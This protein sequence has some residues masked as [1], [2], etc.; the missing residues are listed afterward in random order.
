MNLLLGVMAAIAGYLFGSISAARLVVRLAATQ[1]EVAKIAVE[2]PGYDIVFESDSVSAS[3]VR[4]Q[5][6]ARYG[7]LTA[8]VDMLKIALPTLAVRLWQPNDAYYL[9]LAGAGVLGHAWPL[10]Y[11]FQGGRGESPILGGLL[12][13]DAVGLLVTT[14]V[15]WCLGWVTGNLLVL[16]W[17]FLGLMIPWFWFRTHDFA[18]VLY[19]A[20]VNIVYWIAMLPEIR[21]YF[22]FRGQEQSPTQEELSRFWGMGGHVGRILDRHSLPALF[23][24]K[25]G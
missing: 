13:V 12:A 4:L 20:F 15:G 17:S 2:F 9:V 22:K 6:G 11:R 7:C 25:R 8:I 23:K 24:R 21:Q 19:V 1:P 14:V 5:L 3:A 10:Y 18:P 16:R